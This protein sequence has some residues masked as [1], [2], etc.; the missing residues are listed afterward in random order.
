MHMDYV[1]LFNTLH[2]DFFA[3]ESIRS[4]P[5]EEVFDE[6]LLD[7][8]TFSTDQVALPCPADITFGFYTGDV[9]A[10]RAAVR[11]VDD[12]WVEYFNEDDRI[13]CAFDGGKV[14]SFCLLDEFGTYG[15][16]RVAG[17]GCVGTVPSHRQQGIGLKMVQNATQILKEDGYDLSYIHY[18]HVGHWYARLGYKTIL[19]WNANGIIG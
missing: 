1:A 9:D 12:D 14:V 7:L 11:E 2:P 10:L 4:L 17:P 5:P 19:K 3:D 6:Q 13:Y 16:L 8:R 15:Q 18:T